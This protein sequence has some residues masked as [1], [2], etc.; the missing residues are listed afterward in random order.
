MVYDASLFPGLDAYMQTFKRIHIG[1]GLLKS[2]IY[3][4]DALSSCIYA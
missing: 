1:P 2:N 3:R 4:T